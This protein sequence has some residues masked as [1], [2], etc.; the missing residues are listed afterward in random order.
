MSYQ[1]LVDKKAIIEIE[2]AYDYY[3]NKLIGLGDRFQDS[4]DEH[5]NLLTKNPFFQIRYDIVRCLPMKKFP[6]MIHYS[7]DKEQKVVYIH[8]VFHTS[9]NPESWERK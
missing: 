4:L 8:A 5:F 7:I 6:F 2:D 9:R 1:V 3:E